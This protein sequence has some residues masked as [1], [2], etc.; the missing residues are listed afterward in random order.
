MTY[1]L[2][3]FNQ[4]SA[5]NRVGL[6]VPIN[7]EGPFSDVKTSLDM[8]S[9]KEQLKN[10]VKNNN[11][12]SANSSSNSG[13][14]DNSGSFGVSQTQDDLKKAGKKLLDSFKNKFQGF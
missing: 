1:K 9:V 13:N 8:A 6:I 3:A 4:D 2:S 7:I 5:G 10:L 11:A 14:S 12:N